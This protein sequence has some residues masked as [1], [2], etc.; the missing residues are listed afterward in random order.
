MPCVDTTPSP[1]R[2]VSR[3]SG[4]SIVLIKCLLLLGATTVWARLGVHSMVL[5]RLT[6]ISYPLDRQLAKM[7]SAKASSAHR[8]G[9]RAG[10]RGPHCRQG[11]PAGALACQESARLARP[12]QAP[13][14]RS[15]R[16]DRSTP[17]KSAPARPVPGAG[18]AEDRGTRD[19]SL[20]SP[21][22]RSIDLQAASVKHSAK[23]ASSIVERLIER[24]P[25]AVQPLGQYVDRYIV[26]CGGNQDLSLAGT[27]VLS[28]CLLNG[29]DDL[30]C[31]DAGVR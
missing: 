21:L 24:P 10:S 14:P 1:P 8:R 23:L 30:L 2:T 11:I 17:R 13:T 31:L 9:A 5:C 19:R 15:G 12:G 25:S 28:D 26:E 29:A 16:A 18:R 20:G 4:F 22:H 27:Q 3:P 6:D 7:P